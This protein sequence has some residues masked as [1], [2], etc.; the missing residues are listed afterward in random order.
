MA[1][2]TPLSG[3]ITNHNFKVDLP[4][5]SLVVRLG[6]AGTEHLGI[7][8]SHEGKTAEIAAKAGISA[9]V[10]FSDPANGILV[11]E[12]LEG[13]TL[14]VESTTKPDVFV[15][16]IASI[17]KIHKAAP[18]PG[19]FCPFATVRRYHADAVKRGVKFPA[20]IKDALA[21]AGQIETVLGAD[22]PRVSCHNDLLPGN[23]ID[24]GR[25]VWIVDWEYA[26]IGDPFFDLGNFAIN[27]E[28]SDSACSQVIELY[29]GGP[30]DEK[31]A[32]LHLMR[33]A[34][35]LREAFWGF[36]QSAVSKLD[37]D[38]RQYGDKHLDRFFQNQ[39]GGEFNSW[40]KNVQNRP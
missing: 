24:D 31:L 39:T 13:E 16:T 21:L 7:D 9:G 25:R 27:L 15:R 19:T 23:F 4:N 37:F 14:T 8:R 40:L 29:F 3:G 28:L 10:L 34:S 33:L 11:S 6:G 18:F 2:V 35:D 20:K 5:R 12:F 38:F 26:G 1:V 30:S 36:L 22:R 17:R 32:R